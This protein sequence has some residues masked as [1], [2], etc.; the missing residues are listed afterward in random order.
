MPFNREN[1]VIHTQ[2]PLRHLLKKL[3]QNFCK[4]DFYGTREVGVSVPM[5][6]EAA[7]AYLTC[8]SSVLTGVLRI[9]VRNTRGESPYFL[10]KRSMK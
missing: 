6:T 1:D 2:A 9:R 7:I 3:D 8:G 10:R 4:G 5:V